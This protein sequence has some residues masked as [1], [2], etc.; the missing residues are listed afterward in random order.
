[1]IFNIPIVIG[2]M[3]E[4]NLFSISAFVTSLALLIWSIGETFAYP[5]GPNTSIGTNP[6]ESFH[7][8]YS[9][10]SNIDILS[11]SSGHDFIVTLLETQMVN[12]SALDCR[13][14]LNNVDL[15]YVTYAGGY[16]FSHSFNGLEPLNLVIHDGDTLKVRSSNV[17]SGCWYYM[18]GYY[19]H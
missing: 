9:G 18:T 5:Q 10:S 7:G 17:N 13:I 16:Q 8:S 1:M 15:T 2:V 6:I 19:V 14:L 3:M 12:G 4:K 11:N